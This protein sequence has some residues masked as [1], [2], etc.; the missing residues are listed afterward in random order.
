MKVTAASATPSEAL[1]AKLRGPR[2]GN[3]A[4]PTITAMVEL[5]D[6]WSPVGEDVRRVTEILGPP[7]RE[8]NNELV[9]MFDT[10][11]QAY[12]WHFLLDKQIVTSVALKPY[13]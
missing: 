12:Q 13:E 7:S 1:V 9:Y 5:L 4:V 11:F 3:D 6:H 10:G 8:S 2:A